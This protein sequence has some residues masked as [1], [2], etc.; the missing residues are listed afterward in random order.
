MLNSYEIIIHSNLKSFEQV[1]KIL[2]NNNRR[3][4]A[5]SYGKR[6]VSYA[7]SLIA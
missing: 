3:F 7:K 6:I 1:Q 5:N 4:L 2:P